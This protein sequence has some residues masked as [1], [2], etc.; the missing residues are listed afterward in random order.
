VQ[1]ARAEAQAVKFQQG[2]Y[3]VLAK[4][5]DVPKASLTALVRAIQKAVPTQ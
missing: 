5:N 3:L 1:R 4:W 2:P